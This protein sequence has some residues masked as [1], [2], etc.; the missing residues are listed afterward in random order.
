MLKFYASLASLELKRHFF[1]LKHLEEAQIK[2]QAQ[3]HKKGIVSIPNFYPPEQCK[4]LRSEI[5]R[6]ERTYPQSVWTDS[7]QSDHRIVGAENA[8][9][10]IR[11]FAN[12]SWIRAFAESN[13]GGGA[14]SGF[15]LAARLAA[16]ELNKGSGG[17]WHRDSVLEQF[18]AIIYLSTVSE[19]QGPF[20]YIEGS[21]RLSNI[22]ATAKALKGSPQ[23]YRFSNEDLESALP[24]LGLTIK[25][26][27]AEE[28]TLLLVNTR[29]IHRG[30]PIK[31]GNRYALTN[32]FFPQRSL[33]ND[34]L[35]KFRPVLG[36][37]IP[38]T[39]LIQR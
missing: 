18:K 25:T 35:K 33:R 2:I 3:I 36:V 28:G 4:Q 29:G 5:D 13:M 19:E 30:R 12:D 26:F 9:S 39:P 8:S 34:Y 11:D 16:T 1:S 32:Y 21:H 20:E 7:V 27:N 14:F 38:T 22:F 17:G 15:I 31:S 6:L 24:K 37:D 10:A 23:K